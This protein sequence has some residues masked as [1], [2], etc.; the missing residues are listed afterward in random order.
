MTTKDRPLYAYRLIVE[1]P[2]GVDWLHPPH[3]WEQERAEGEHEHMD[4]FDW[5]Q[6]R[7]YLSYSGAK[8]RADLLRRYGC[9]VGIQRSE[10]I[11]WT[12]P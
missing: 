1:Y 9:V 12:E 5:P 2:E 4:G 8:K 7:R 11:E 3:L 6:V 10:R